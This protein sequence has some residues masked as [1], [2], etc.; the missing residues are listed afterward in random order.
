MTR[1]WAR[2]LRGW[3]TLLLALQALGGGAVALAHAQDVVVAP[4]A[5]EASHDARC[6]I[7]H[8]VARCALCQ[9][10]GLRVMAPAAVVVP[11]PPVP[12]LAVAGRAPV[13]VSAGALPPPPPSRAPPVAI[14]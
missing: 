4:A 10:A 6:A 1:H 13:F 3:A 7:L 5:F 11:M 8:D 14:S 12:R 2:G 9:Y